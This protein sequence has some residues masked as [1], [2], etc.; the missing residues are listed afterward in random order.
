MDVE[1][2]LIIYGFSSISVNGLI[3]VTPISIDDLEH[4]DPFRLWISVNQRE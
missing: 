3:N 4:L 2:Y 1:Y